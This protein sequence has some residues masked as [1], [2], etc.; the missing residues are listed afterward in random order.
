M[1][2]ADPVIATAFAVLAERT[3][4]AARTFVTSPSRWSPQDVWLR[5]VK[6]RQMTRPRLR[7]SLPDRKSLR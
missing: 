1:S 5:R 2:W 7:D 4:T 6:P 3:A